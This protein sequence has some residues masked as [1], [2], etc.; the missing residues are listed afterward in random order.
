MEVWDIS[1]LSMTYRYTVKIKQ[2]FKQKKWDFG[3]VNLKKKG[4]IQGMVIQDN[5]SKPQEKNSTTKSH[6]DIG[7]WCEFHKIR[8]HNTSE[9][10][11]KQSLV[12]KLKAS[13]LDERTDP[14]LKL[15]KGN[16]EGK[17]IIDA[18]HNASVVTAKV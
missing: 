2:K 3:S 17:Q 8:T 13:E 4:Q 10:G 7:R 6:K 1:S 12:A 18:E 5:L 14:E 15:D 9:C 11:T 16:E